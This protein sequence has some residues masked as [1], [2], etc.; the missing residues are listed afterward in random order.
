ML[1]MIPITRQLAIEEREIRETFVRSPGPGGQHVNKAATAVQV[2]FDVAHS[3]S[4]PPEIRERVIR[5]AGRRLT[6]DGVLEIEARRFRSQERNR[7]D[8]RNR[9]IALIRQAA[10]PP[11]PRHRTKP[12]RGAEERRLEAKRRRAGTKRQ[13]KRIDEE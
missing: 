6:G 7:Q 2:R 3:Q 4:L 1:E 13:R 12:P 11:K 5:L 8:A 10:K 9:L